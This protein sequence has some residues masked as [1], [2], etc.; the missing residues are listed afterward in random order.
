M[1]WLVIIIIL[2]LLAVWLKD[3]DNVS[4]F[5]EAGRE[6]EIAR[7]AKSIWQRR[8]KP[9]GKDTEIWLEAEKK[10]DSACELYEKII[11]FIA[12]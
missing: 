5:A 6:R 9:Q 2:S 8:G 10:V 3:I 11:K 7:Q 1:I 12:P 4:H